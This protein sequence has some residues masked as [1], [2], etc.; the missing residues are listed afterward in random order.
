MVDR[1]W[2]LMECALCGWHAVVPAKTPRGNMEALAA[3]HSATCRG[4]PCDTD[5]ALMYPAK[6]DDMKIVCPKCGWSAMVPSRAPDSQLKA[7]ADKHTAVCMGAQRDADG[8]LPYLT[9]TDDRPLRVRLEQL[10]DAHH[11][12]AIL[13]DGSSAV[14][15]WGQQVASDCLSLLGVFGESLATRARQRERCIC[16]LC[17]ESHAGTG[18]CATHPAGEHRPSRDEQGHA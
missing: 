12:D 15:A 11:F 13:N 5:G 18:R 1:D 3:R 17:G 7:L 6:S 10:R 4:V 9:E 16:I 8:A 2:K 14:R